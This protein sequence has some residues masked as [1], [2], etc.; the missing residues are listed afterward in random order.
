MRDAFPERRVPES[1]D[2]RADLLRAARMPGEGAGQGQLAWV[3]VMAAAPQDPRIRQFVEEWLSP[4][5]AHPLV[6]VLSRAAQ[7]EEIE[8]SI[9][10]DLIADI[11]VSLTLNRLITRGANLQEQE[12]EQMIDLIVR[13]TGLG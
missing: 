5:L 3:R 9:N 2:L 11:F 8:R 7:R 12:L 1:G 13:P 10:V 6:E 4:R